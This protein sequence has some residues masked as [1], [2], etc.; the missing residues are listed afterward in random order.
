MRLKVL[1][2]AL[3]SLEE[4]LGEDTPI[5]LLSLNNTKKS[6][7]KSSGTDVDAISLGLGYESDEDKVKCIFIATQETLDWLADSKKSVTEH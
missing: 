6:L 1:I 7:N 4:Q 5:L 3:L 2:S